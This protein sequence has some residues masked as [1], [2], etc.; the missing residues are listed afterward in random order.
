MMM[1]GFRRFHPLMAMAYIPDE[2]VN[3]P[4]HVVKPAE[5][6]EAAGGAI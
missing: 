1:L 5:G 2:K 3:F 6:M 4:L